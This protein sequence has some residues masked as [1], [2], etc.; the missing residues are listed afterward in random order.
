MTGETGL[1]PWHTVWLLHSWDGDV[2]VCAPSLTLPAF[3]D[4]DG[5]GVGSKTSSHHC[6]PLNTPISRV[7]YLISFE[8]FLGEFP[9]VPQLY[10]AIKIELE[11]CHP[12]SL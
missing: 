3:S 1:E 4:P 11:S 7:V 9:V 6:S 2:Y 8:I 12:S 5:E 10:K